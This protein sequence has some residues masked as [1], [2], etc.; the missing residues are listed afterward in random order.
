MSITYH[1]YWD[2]L[3]GVGVW[4]GCGGRVLNPVLPRWN[5][6]EALTVTDKRQTPSVKSTWHQASFSL[7]DAKNM[8]EALA[9]GQA[10]G[11]TPPYSLLSWVENIQRQGS[12]IRESLFMMMMTISL[13]LHSLCYLN[14]SPP[15]PPP[16]LSLSLTLSLNF[17]S[18]L[19]SLAL[20]ESLCQ[21]SLS[22]RSCQTKKTGRVNLK[23][24]NSDFYRV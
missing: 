23:N 11:P 1:T 21:M 18:L 5:R 6:T 8:T 24:C 15:Q 13:C 17:S 16:F 19:F 20:S 3:Y 7:A 10:G 14:P 12:S 2:C 22:L 4:L 9:G